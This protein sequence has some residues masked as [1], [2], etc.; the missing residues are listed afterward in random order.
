[1]SPSNGRNSDPVYE[2]AK[3]YLDSLPC[4]L[5]SDFLIASP[6]RK[7]D[8]AVWLTKQ[9]KEVNRRTK[10]SKFRKKL[11]DREG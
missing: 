1:V 5:W 7:E 9:V 2:A 10:K 11:G 4:S 8:A 3:E 6:D